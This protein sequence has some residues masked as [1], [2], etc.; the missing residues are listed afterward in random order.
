VLAPAIKHDPPSQS[1]PTSAP[2]TIEAAVTDNVGVQEVTLYYR[3]IGSA[4][5]TTVNM[6]P[7]GND[8]YA[9]TIPP[10]R[11]AEPGLEYYIQAADVAGNMAL[12]GFAFD[13]LVVN[14]V[15][16][17]PPPVV[18]VMPEPRPSPAEA[19]AMRTEP[20]KG[21]SWYKKWWV[22]TLVGS[23]V[24]IGTAA[25]GGDGGGD[26][27]SNPPPSD[28]GSITITGPIPE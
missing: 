13:P 12:R 24:L 8:T 22:W 3:H 10:T 23:A 16:M 9:A 7:V 14:V 28:T 15:P 25:S 2:L 20:A 21:R 19:L 5:F 18:T 27:G 26:S 6:A 4:D 17:A 11:V 1:A